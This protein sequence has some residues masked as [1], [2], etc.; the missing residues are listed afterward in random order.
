[1]VVKSSLLPQ[2]PVP[3]KP[4][5]G[6]CHRT[7][8]VSFASLSSEQIEL[9]TA[10]MAALLLGIGY[11]LAWIPSLPPIVSNS[12]LILSCCFGGFFATLE[13]WQSLRHGRFEIDFLMIVAAA[14]AG[15]LGAWAEGA[16]LLA[17][18]SMGHALEHFAM[19]RA[20]KSIASLGQ[21][22][23]KTAIVL[24]ENIQHEIPIDELKIGDIV[25]VKPDSV[26]AADGVVIE[27]ESGVDQSPITG[28]SIP[29]DKSPASDFDP[30]DPTQPLVPA[31]HRVFSGT[32]NGSGALK[33][34][35]TRETH[36]T[37]LSRLMKLVTEAESQRSPTQRLTD[38][39]E[40]YYVPSVLIV[41]VLLLGAFLVIDETFGDSFYRA[42]ATLVAASPCALAIAT[43]SAVLS[44]IARAGNSGLLFKGGGPL[45]M[46]GKVET[47]AFDKTGTL[48]M[49]R[50]V[51]T[52]VVPAHGISER[53]L[54][55]TAAAVERLSPHP[56]ART[57]WMAA[58]ER[59]GENEIP[60]ADNLQSITGRGV[61][62]SIDGRQITVGTEKLLVQDMQSTPVPE[63][64]LEQLNRLKHGGRTT[65]IVKDGERFLGTLGLQD[66]P[67]P[68]ALPTLQ[69]LREMGIAN[70]VM[71]SGDHQAVADQIARDVG[72]NKAIGD[73]M[74]EDK[75]AAVK[76]LASNG[77]IAMVGDG[78]N[79]APAMATASVAIAMGAA[80]SDVALETADVALMGDDLS[81]LPFAIALSRQ[82]S[83]IIRQNLWIS[84][85]MIAVLVPAT[86]TGL[87]LAAAVV[88][89]EGS[90]LVVVLNALRLLGFREKHKPTAS[91][92]INTQRHAA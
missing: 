19:G 25:I 32:L 89:H 82:A 66:R 15:T 50:P 71:L 14:G 62:A 30:S 58:R 35:V 84:L 42:M 4:K 12:V 92:Q 46:L 90:T 20:R 47:I 39:F 52:D 86:M 16:L 2:S 44:G 43:P 48:T 65:M 74:P 54:L 63:D 79:D 53:E 61:R 40:K 7:H 38:S 55:V 28:E 8:S 68:A 18:F 67:R 49:G 72:L 81:R 57:I 87:N 5:T 70:M 1:M 31:E 10:I 56:L 36:D 77:L 64:L 60:R 26:I 45:E 21:L 69:S 91:I 88:F 37:T 22:R 59:Y 41:V 9:G 78:V 80:G 85:G 51:L 3:E 73:L 83:R 76:Q 6:C 17:L 27:G 11:G 33:I 29:V 24:R 23:P 13:S 75:V 34:F